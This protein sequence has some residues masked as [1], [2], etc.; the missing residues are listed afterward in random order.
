MFLSPLLS[1]SN[2]KKLKQLPEVGK[3]VW[4]RVVGGGVMKGTLSLLNCVKC[5]MHDILSGKGTVDILLTGPVLFPHKSS[6]TIHSFIHS[7]IHCLLI[8]CNRV[9]VTWKSI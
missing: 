2:E 9:R 8:V 1:K 4:Q 5:H 7:F 6:I 3:T